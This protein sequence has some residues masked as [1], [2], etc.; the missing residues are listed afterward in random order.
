MLTAPLWPTAQAAVCNPADF[1]GAYGFLL[2]GDSKIGFGAQPAAALGRLVL[3]D[4]GKISGTVSAGFTGLLLGNPVTG[5]YE[6]HTDC[7]ITWSLQDDSGNFQHF[8]GTAT[9]D[10]KRITFRQTDPGGAP[11]GTM[12]RTSSGCDAGEFQGR[13]KLT[14][15]GHT[16]NVDSG[17][18]SGDVSLSGFL[19]SDDAG[20]VSFSRDAASPAAPAGTY[21]PDDDCF[22]H[23]TVQ[24]P[25]GGNEAP[26][27]NF[28]AIL[29]DGG[30]EMIGIQSDPGAV[31]SLRLV[32]Q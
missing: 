20:G 23:L 10:A 11:N 12:L 22:V 27:M 26:E 31:V 3:D 9:E 4:S 17:Q 13:Y 8:Q 18:V 1:S 15:S 30:K 24:L 21:E 5:G 25:A 32:S 14:L 7:S 19:D 2:T 29:A 6:A 28:R 16:V